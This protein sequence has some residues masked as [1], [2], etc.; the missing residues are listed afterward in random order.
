MRRDGA[1][2]VGVTHLLVF[3]GCLVQ[4][5]TVRV[6]AARIGPLSTGWHA[7][8]FD[9]RSISYRVDG[10]GPVCVSIFDHATP[11]DRT[12]VYVDR[13]TDSL[14]RDLLAIEA[15]RRHIGLQRVCVV[16]RG[17]GDTVAQQYARVFPDHVE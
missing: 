14:E 7:A 17:Y 12:V 10:T 11:P 5:V 2:T 6:P 15:V 16:G 8:V 4:P 13:Q 9:D 3:A 1:M